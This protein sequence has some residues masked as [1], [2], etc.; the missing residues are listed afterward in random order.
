LSQGHP[1]LRYVFDSCHASRHAGEPLTK[2]QA[3]TKASFEEYEELACDRN[4]QLYR[5]VFYS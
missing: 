1:R 4:R 2:R 3:Q 5:Y